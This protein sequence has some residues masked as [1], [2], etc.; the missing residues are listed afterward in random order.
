MGERKPESGP[1]PAGVATRREVL[2][3]G[4]GL[5][6]LL[7]AGRWPQVATAGIHPPARAKNIIYIFLAGGV[8]QLDT[9]DPKPE[10]ARLDGQL[11]PCLL[12]TSP[13][14]RDRG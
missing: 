12:Y 8:S 10:L 2:G 3:G 4:L 1:K 9:F 11:C 13:S 7:A 14:P 5:A 6:G